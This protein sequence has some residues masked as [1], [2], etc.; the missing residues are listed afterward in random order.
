MADTSEEAVQKRAAEQLTLATAQMVTQVCMHVGVTTRTAGPRV[1]SRA[2]G[3][4]LRVGHQEQHQ[5]GS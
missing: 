1:S 2:D 3:D 5:H 4:S